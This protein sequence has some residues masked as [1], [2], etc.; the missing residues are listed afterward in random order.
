MVSVGNESIWYT[1]D[2]G[3]NARSPVAKHSTVA[4][5]VS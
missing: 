4:T 1:P 2:I 5:T 3:G